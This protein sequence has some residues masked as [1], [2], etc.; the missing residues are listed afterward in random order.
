MMDEL[1]LELNTSSPSK[2][3]GLPKIIYRNNDSDVYAKESMEE[4]FSLWGIKNYQRHS[5]K[6]HG[7]TNPDWKNIVLDNVTM[8]PWTDVSYSLNLIDSI[9]EWYDSESSETCIFADDGL[10]FS[11]V[12]SW[13]FDWKFLE[14]QL[15]YNWDCIQLYTSSRRSIKMHLHPWVNTN[16]S[17]RCFMISRT[18]A[19]RLK[20]FHFA[21]NKYKLAYEAPNKSVKF[22]EYG[23]L[24]TFFFDIGVTYTLP[25]FAFNNTCKLS[26]EERVGSDA[27]KY[28]WKYKSNKFSNFEFFHYN[29][30]DGEWKMEVMFDTQGGRPE[31][32]MDEVEGIMIWI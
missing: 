1:K 16:K 22:E 12:N 7:D 13:M 28:W 11:V 15:P 26:V 30:G 5:N 24:D 21:D 2:L 20:H 3:D 29:K 14:H 9:I 8:L 10:D 25:V 19:K 32:Y 4:Q 6:Y 18:F 31:V 17:Q 27:I 23:L